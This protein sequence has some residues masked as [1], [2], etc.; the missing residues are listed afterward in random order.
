VTRHGRATPLVWLSVFKDELKDARNAYA[1]P[2]QEL[3]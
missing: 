3:T 2:L 1:I